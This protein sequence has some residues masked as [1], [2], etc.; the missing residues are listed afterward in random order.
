[1]QDIDDCKSKI[2][3]YLRESDPETN[4]EDLDDCVIQLISCWCQAGI[5]P[6]AIALTLK[7]ISLHARIINWLRKNKIQPIT[8]DLISAIETQVFAG[9]T[10]SEACEKEMAKRNSPPSRKMKGT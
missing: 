10:V 1:M 2:A 7:P 9:N 3:E 5:K 6:K 4:I 8:E